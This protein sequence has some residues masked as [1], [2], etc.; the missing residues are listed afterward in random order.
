[1]SERV[2][3]TSENANTGESAGE[4]GDA[5]RYPATRPAGRRANDRRHV[6]EGAV[7]SERAALL[8]DSQRRGL[9]YATDLWHDETRGPREFTLGTERGTQ[10]CRATPRVTRGKGLGHGGLIR[11]VTDDDGTRWPAMTRDELTV[12]GITGPMCPARRERAVGRPW[13]HHVAGWGTS[14]LGIGMCKIHGGNAWRVKAEAGWVVG[15]GFAEELN[16][17]PWEALLMAVRIAAGKVAYI[18]SVLATASSDLE[19]EGRAVVVDSGSV[20]DASGGA[21]SAQ[22]QL[23]SRLLLHPDTGEPL[24]MGGYRDLSFWVTKSELWHD[25]L[26]KTA[27]MAVDA[28]VAAWQVQ[29]VEQEAASIARVLNAVVENLAEEDHLSEDVITRVRARMRTE[30][31][32]IDAERRDESVTL[33][34]RDDDG[35]RLIEGTTV[36]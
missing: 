2:E 13:C 17:N 15:H 6:E 22:M 10:S 5:W 8:A 34:S 7:G 14:H 9:R 33:T 24:G 36:E 29:Q 32:R 26:A 1:M 11:W 19:L 23:Q 27:K 4:R 18:E 20:T 16:V 25:R 21:Q 3:S 30:L 35:G 31:L 28:G 12:N